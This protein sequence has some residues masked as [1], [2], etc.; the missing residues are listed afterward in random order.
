MS[1]PRPQSTGSTPPPP[2]TPPPA[3]T[4]QPAPSGH[5][6]AHKSS[7][8]PATPRNTQ[9]Q[10]AGN[11][12]R[13]G[14]PQRTWTPLA[15]VVGAAHAL[16]RRGFRFLVVIDAVTLF[17]AAMAINLVRFGLAWPTYPFSHYLV[18]FSIAVLLQIGVNYFAGLYERR[19]RIGLQPLLPRVVMAMIIG[20]G[21]QA[22]AY[23]ALDRYLMPRLNLVALVVV[24]SAILAA[25]RRL[26]TVLADL[27]RGR[28]RVVI[29]GPPDAVRAATDHLA[30]ERKHVTVVATAPS[31]AHLARL[32]TETRAT[33]VLLLE[34]SD[35]AGLFPEPLNTLEAAGVG[36]HQRVSAQETTLGLRTVTQI[37]GMPFTRLRS[38]SVAGHQLRL[39]RLFDLVTV[40]VTAPL[41]VPVL[42]VL[43]LWVRAKAGPGV[44]F[45]QARVGRNG[46]VFRVVKFR[47]MV[48][49]A[50]PDGPVLATGDDPRVV[51]AL[52]WMRS[53][54]ADELPQLWNVLRGQMSLVGPRPE[55]PELVADITR[56]TAGYARRHELP[57]GITG[58]AQVYGHYDSSPESKL[59]YDLQYLVNWSLILDIQI[60]A[61]TVSVVVTR[62]V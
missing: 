46:N 33:D 43:A 55:R 29:I 41:S 30:G 9:R 42:G 62:R 48:P 6:P 4:P 36:V 53:T 58:M 50:E 45:R 12:V 57:P 19:P 1:D 22:I 38:H 14:A 54:R 31:P 25:N 34:L 3:G 24:G 59:G 11:R 26:S 20:V 56:T 51:P 28:S 32:T 52:R 61:R 13:S 16:W 5:Q 49:D 40:I 15:P 39:K 17:G 18:G 10:P 60:L 8:R 47:T 37:A 21:V 27:R 7:E 35:F 2:A 23:I 44:L